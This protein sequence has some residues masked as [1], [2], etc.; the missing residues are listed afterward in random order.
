MDFVADTPRLAG[1][2]L[3]VADDEPDQLEFLATV[4]EDHGAEVFRAMDGDEAF[5]LVRRERPDLLTLDL[6]MP[7]LNA[8]DVFEKIRRD[9]ELE[10]TKVCIITGHPELRKLI[11][12]RSVRPPEGYMDKPVDEERLLYNVRRI[13]EV[14]HSGA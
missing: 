3:V 9:P 13:L 11:Y 10:G 5:D 4:F 7:G 6:E 2:R 8:G 14:A 1:R 12:D